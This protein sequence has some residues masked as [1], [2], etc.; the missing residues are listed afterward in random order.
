ME[1]KAAKHE[2]INPIMNVIDQ[3]RTI[4][5]ESGNLT[6]WVGYPSAEV[7]SEDIDLHQ[8]FVCEI[9]HEIVGYF[10]LIIGDDPDPNYRI[11]EGGNWLDEKPYGVIHRL[12][13]GRQVKGIAQK[14]FD[15]AF[16]KID[17]VRV[18]THHDNVPMQNFLRK[19]GFSYCGIIYVSDG[20]P[21]DA[22]QKRA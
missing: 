5:R 7:I 17:N 2:D 11:I 10:C 6:Q 3:A 22:F 19:N 15:Y 20:S 21:R 9:D 4:M 12:A 13:S 8:A 14:A 1:I 18:D 16:S